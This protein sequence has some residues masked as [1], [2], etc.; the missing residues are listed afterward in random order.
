[1]SP[2]LRLAGRRSAALFLLLASAAPADAK[3]I[4]PGPVPATVLE[5]IDGDTV[6]LRAH[7]WLGQEVE[8]AVR[9]DGV[10]AP[11]L[12]GDCAAERRLAAAARD[13]L[14]GLLG[15]GRVSLRD[16]AQDKYG[17]R[18]VAKIAVMGGRDVGDA[19]LA[20]GLARPYDGG[21]RGSWC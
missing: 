8:T 1:M 7:I 18:V 13:Y 10:N 9:L 6:K 19:L 11:E 16:I 17:G 15:D 2:R 3:E 4:L 21:A 12:R 14:A 5:V 20:A